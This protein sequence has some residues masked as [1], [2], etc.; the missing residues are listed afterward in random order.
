MQLNMASETRKLFSSDIHRPI[1]HYL[2]PSNWMNDPNGVIQWNGKYHLFY[3]HNPLGPLW[4]NMNWGHA[5]S[6]DLIHWTDLPLALNPD[7]SDY[8]EAGC[9]SGCCVNNDGVPT[10]FYT[11]T[12]GER[13]ENQVQAIATS[14][15]DLLTWQK[16]PANP[17]IKTVP[18]E[19]NQTSD[20]RDPYVWRE[21]DTWYMVLG[22]RIAGEAGDFGV[23]FLYRSQNLVD[24]EYLNPLIIG[25]DKKHGAIWEC[26]NFFKLGDKWVLIISAHQGHMTDTVY[27]F[28][29]AFTDHRFIPETSGVLD[30]GNLYAP[31]SFK[32]DHNRQVMFGWLR[33]ARSEVDQRLAGW[34]GVQAI[35]RVLAL[36]NQNRLNMQPV[37][38]LNTIR[39]RNVTVEPTDITQAETLDIRGLHLDIEAEFR[40]DETGYVGFSLACAEDGSEKTDIIYHADGNRLSVHK[41]FPRT[42]GAMT[43]H[44]REVSHQLDAGE[45]LR[46]R[47]LLDGSVL[48]IVANGRTSLSRRI[49]PTD[50]TSNQVKLLGERASVVSLNIWEM[51]SIWH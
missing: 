33:E 25:D 42:N 7:N 29:G 34:S 19:A 11:A 41:H 31:L 26:P 2:P 15:D 4:G 12:T 13:C 47:I 10:I 21:G 5:V 17:V 37:P 32:D 36:D 40:V 39:G 3:Q 16:H 1:Y 51:P 43:T 44:S 48:E 35:P 20:F 6:E 14:E 22:S 27:Y 24:W 23:I 8:D 30:Y 28:V 38:E 9:F 45:P 46:L 50:S 18:S 49:Y